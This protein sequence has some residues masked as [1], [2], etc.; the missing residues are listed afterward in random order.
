MST[1]VM[2]DIRDG[3]KHWMQKAFAH[4]KGALH[5]DLHVPQGQ[6]I[7]E[8]KLERAEHS[9]NPTIRKRAQA[10]ENARGF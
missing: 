4:N 8:R 5:A 2:K 1:R 7:P 3:G 10:A 9:R 6:K